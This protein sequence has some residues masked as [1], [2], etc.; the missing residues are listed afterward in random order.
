MGST[1][2]ASNS[3]RSVTFAKAIALDTK[4]VLLKAFESQTWGMFR[5]MMVKNNMTI[6]VEQADTLKGAIDR[7][8][9]NYVRLRPG[10]ESDVSGSGSYNIALS[11]SS[12][13]DLIWNTKWSVKDAGFSG[14]IVS[15]SDQ[16]TEN[17]WMGNYV[18]HYLQKIMDGMNAQK[19][20]Q[21]FDYAQVMM[22]AAA[23]TVPFYNYTDT[24]ARDAGPLRELIEI[25]FEMSRV[26]ATN[27][28]GTAAEPSAWLE[29]VME[30]NAK[31]AGEG[32]SQFVAPFDEPS[33]GWG[34]R[35]G[36]IC[37]SAFDYAQRLMRAA[38]GVQDAGLKAQVMRSD[39]LSELVNL[40]GAY[41]A[42]SPNIDGNTG[43]FLDTIF[44]S[45]Q[46]GNS[47]SSQSSQDFETFL[48][49]NQTTIMYNSSDYF[50]FQSKIVRGTIKLSDPDQ[51]LKKVSFTSNLISWGT[52]Y[53]SDIQ[54]NTINVF[55]P[56]GYFGS[57][58][59]AKNSLDVQNCSQIISSTKYLRGLSS[60]EGIAISAMSTL[61]RSARIDKSVNTQKE[62]DEFAD[63][64]ERSRNEWYKGIRKY[65]GYSVESMPIR[66]KALTW[67]LFAWATKP[68]AYANTAYIPSF[69]YPVREIKGSKDNPLSTCNR[70]I[71]DAY[72]IG[73]GV[74]YGLNGQNGT[75]PTGQSFP[76]DPRPGYPVDANEL[77][78]SKS[79]TGILSH[80][81]LT[82]D[83]K[84]GDIISFADNSSPDPEG[85]T[86]LL[87]GYGIYI[88]ARRGQDYIGSQVPD[89]IQIKFIPNKTR[90]YRK[91]RV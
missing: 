69:G 55:D 1:I 27:P 36:D 83:P 9:W 63:A 45:P 26:G 66:L 19:L 73:A 52:E 58:S 56:L 44:K 38:A 68:S 25:G 33:N 35:Y 14:P 86:G 11:K 20:I 23:R 53:Y 43:F 59:K 64:V 28:A 3:Q 2:V 34:S 71:G 18:Y 50:N 49:L 61:A 51:L 16:Q 21:G 57:I 72:A 47:V 10:M 75:Y 79:D 30:G 67:G 88:S 31:L 90:N 82:E 29:A 40:G 41:A 91:F 60:E 4:P 6:S 70:F 12:F 15:I 87:L 8:S 17:G 24:P 46:S 54:N 89:G 32:L 42:L 65:S 81:P 74:G 80:L 39:T 77:S 76:F 37:R 85:H 13:A 84:M 7:F 48:Q 5:G 78:S 62:R 22:D